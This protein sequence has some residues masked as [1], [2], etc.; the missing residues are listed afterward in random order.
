MA[1][2]ADAPEQAFRLRKFQGTS[3]EPDSTFLG[4]TYVNH[5]E[6]WIPA[7][8]Y[9]LA[10][11]P[12]SSLV[13]TIGF[14]KTT[15]LFAARSPDG[16]LYLYAFRLPLGTTGIG[17][18][19]QQ[20]IDEAAFTGSP[21]NALFPNL[22]AIGR[23]IQFRDRMY[24]GN[25]VDPLVTWKIGDAPA[26][27]LILGPITDLGA[28]ADAAAVV[29]AA[30]AASLPAGTYAYCWALFNL[31]GHANA[32]LYDGRTQPAVITVPAQQVVKF[33][34]LTA[35]ANQEARLFVSPRNYPIEYATMQ[36]HGPIADVVLDT[37]DVTDTRVP[38]AGGTLALGNF[39]TGNMFVIWRNR[40]VFAGMASDPYS[41]FAT[42]VILPGLEQAGFNQ[43][44]LFPAFAKVPLPFPVTGIGIA[45][46]TTDQDA[47]SPLLFF[48]ATKTFIVQ[49][50]PFDPNGEATLVEVSSRVGCVAHDTI[51]NTPFGTFFAGIDSIYMIPTGG[52]YPRDVGWPIADQVRSVS[53]AFRSS[54]VATFHKQF[55][56]IAMPAPGG[57]I[58]SAQWWL[59]LRAGVGD[60]PSWWGPHTGQT[61]TAMCADPA[62]TLEIDRGYAAIQ[63]VNN[64]SIIATHQVGLYTDYYPPNGTTPVP[65]RSRLRS[66]RFD[67]DQPFI[68]KIF[69]RLRCIA[70]TGA[71]S[72]LHVSFQT[73]GGVTWAIDPI[74]IGQDMDDP[75][76]WV[77][78]TPT[79]PPP[80]P[81]NKA[82]N[83]AKFATVA[84]IEVQTITPAVRPR[85]LSV[86]VMLTHDPA[87]D[88][89]DNDPDTFKSGSDIQLRDF[90][91]LFIF[92]G[93]K[94][95]FL[96]ER[97]FK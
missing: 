3:T 1:A 79:S 21:P 35:G 48:T 17:S 88:A 29:A 23:S 12:G 94:V 63:N 16:H 9:L 38:M 27:T 80:P 91:L 6:N 65:V 84:P 67:A 82:W 83:T 86:I 87:L 31:P 93:R 69:T 19:V 92:S 26:N 62:S 76:E 89:S 75:A 25:G 97:A 2:P 55:Y 45:G 51:V 20:S 39:R 8:S 4:P 44:T 70:Q 15:H 49:G 24:A 59:D 54:M 33:P 7:R 77:H 64:S 57:A 56:K 72:A 74:I 53:A 50:D 85:G 41:V 81:P 10:K 40:V 32:G 71:K 68:T 73:D 66:G 78:L 37:V 95:R 43:G 28:K 11:R 30:G 36:A 58:N 61:V 60:T 90:E 22:T 42:D 96:R 14:C 18:S 34:I 47:T 5:S 52:G 13:Q 46:V